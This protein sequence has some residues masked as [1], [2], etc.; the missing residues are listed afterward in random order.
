[1]YIY[2]YTCTCVLNI[3]TNLNLSHNTPE[4]NCK[5]KK[6]QWFLLFFFIISFSIILSHMNEFH[7][8]NPE[9]TCLEV[10]M[11]QNKTLDLH[12][13]PCQTSLMQKL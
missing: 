1:M 2:I 3:F 11:A 5:A 4:G 7:G 12:L 9:N 13:P 8:K 6:Q 10:G